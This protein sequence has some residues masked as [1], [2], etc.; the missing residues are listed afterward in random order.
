MDPS[1]WSG[2]VGV[3][4]T[5]ESDI[6]KKAVNEIFKAVVKKD[7]KNQYQILTKFSLRKSI[8]ILASVPNSNQIVKLRMLKNR[9]EDR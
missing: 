2:E 7:D 1:E 3:Y 5:E 4:A 8:R 9:T 6:E